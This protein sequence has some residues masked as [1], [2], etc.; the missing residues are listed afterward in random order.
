MALVLPLP[1]EVVTADDAGVPSGSITPEFRDNR[2]TGP[3]VEM[4]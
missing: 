1:N 4:G 2:P 3:Q